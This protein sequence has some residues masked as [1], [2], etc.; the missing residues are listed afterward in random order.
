MVSLSD[1]RE[2]DLFYHNGVFKPFINRYRFMGGLFY[3]KIMKCLQ[4]TGQGL[5]RVNQL[6]GSLYQ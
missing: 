4:G 6:T 1:T 2:E 5:S 3:F